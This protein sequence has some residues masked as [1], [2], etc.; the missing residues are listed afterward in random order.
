VRVLC[1]GTEYPPA[2]RGGY[3]QQCADL[4]AHLRARG[5]AVRVLSGAGRRCPTDAGV[6]RQLPRF[7]VRPVP[8]S[9]A[10]AAA[11]ERRSATVL[12]RHLAAFAPD[13]V[14]WW[15]L[16]ELSQ[17]L[18]A[19]V[20]ARGLPA[21][22]VVCD[23]WME[24]GPSRDPWCRITGRRPSFDGVRWLCCSDWLRRRLGLPDADVV[25]PGVD[26][27][28]FF[29]RPS[30]PPW[31]GRL[32]YAGRL[33]RMKGVGDAYA[34]LA[35]LPGATLS[36]IGHG[37][38]PRPHRRLRVEPAIDRAALGARMRATD[39]LL[40]PVRWDEP[41][42]L[43]PLEAMA[44]AVPVVA[45]AT[46]GAAEY[47][48]DETNALLV[49]PG[50]PPAIARAVRR[51]AGDEALRSRL[52]AGGRRTAAAASLAAANGAVHAVLA[53]A[54]AGNVAA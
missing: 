10:A 39:V 6:H 21:V 16:G 5:H 42:G 2:T 18:V 35:R 52:V 12:E 28:A 27:Q 26:S 23:T 9:R 54:V 8:T 1:V 45:T 37:D 49:P 43:V 24:D 41:W 19:R 7:P 25:H 51:L 36:V 31:R 38:P 22:G 44:C 33:S 4:V 17:S 50:D 30:A 3:E 46:G 48:R 13:V 53:E 40:F 29:E 15:R 20:A 11:A 14:C 32:L 34:A 47:L